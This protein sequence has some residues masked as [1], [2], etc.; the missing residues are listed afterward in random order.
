M[1]IGRHRRA[2][3]TGP[4]ARVPSMEGGAKVGRR[5]GHTGKRRGSAVGAGVCAWMSRRGMGE[6]GELDGGAAGSESRAGGG[7][8]T[9][10]G[11]GSGSGAD[12][13]GGAADG[14]VGRHR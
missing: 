11:A 10:D 4:R 12:G 2:G 9:D 7:G 13:G 3:W 8:G 14:A 1:R 6:T 5:A